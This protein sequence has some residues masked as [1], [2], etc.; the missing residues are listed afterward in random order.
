[1]DRRVLYVFILHLVY[2]HHDDSPTLKSRRFVQ[3]GDVTI[4]GLF[5]IHAGSCKQKDF[6][7]AYMAMSQ[8][9]VYAIDSINNDT[10]LLPNI[11]L[12]YEIYDSC[13]TDTLAMETAMEI[14]NRRKL[15]IMY[16]KYS[17]IQKCFSREQGLG[18]ILALIGTGSSDSSIL[19]ANLLQV[20]GI[21]LISYAA[22][23]DELSKRSYP[24]FLRTVPPDHF[25][26]QAMADIAHY[27]NWTYIAAIAAD[28][29]YG[30]SAIYYFKKA[31]NKKRTCL[32]MESY[33]SDKGP[34]FKDKISK[35]ITELKSLKN[36]QVVVVI[37]TSTQ[38]RLLLQEAHKQNVDKMTWIAS[39]GWGDSKMTQENDT[40]PVVKGLLGIIYRDV[41]V[42]DFVEYLMSLNSTYQPVHWWENFW[43]SQFKCVF[44]L[45]NPSGKLCTEDLRISKTMYHSH[46]H[47]SMSAYVI[48]AVYAI[49][50]ALDAMRKCK[51]P[52]GLLDGG[53]CPSFTTAIN[54]KD[55]LVYIKAV[56]FTSPVSRVSFDAHGDPSGT[57]NIVNL[58][59]RN[60]SWEFHRIGSWVSSS[61]PHLDIDDDMIMW[62]GDSKGEPPKSVCQEVCSPGHWQTAS[63][64]CCWQCIECPLDEISQMYGA[65]NCTKCPLG[66]I[67][68][69]NHTKCTKVPI[70]RISYSHPFGLC[71][72]VVSCLGLIATACITG[73]F[74][75]YNNSPIV[76]ASNRELC[77]MLLFCI[78]MCY[79]APFIYLAKP[80]Q[81]GCILVQVWFY[82]FYTT[83][84]AILG[85]K[86]NK[87][88]LLFEQRLPRSRY[89]SGFFKYR[90]VLIV[91][92]AML[93]ELVVIVI[94]VCVDPPHPY[95]NKD[96]R[97]EYFYTC[98]PSLNQAGQVCQ[99]LLMSILI[100]A[101]IICCYF[102]YKARRLPDNFNEGKFIAFSMYILSISWLTFYP[103]ILN[104]QDMYN[105]VVL[106]ITTFIAASG[107]LGCMFWP[108]IYIIIWCP[109]KN[110]KH[111]MQEQ[112]SQH[113]FRHNTI[114]TRRSSQRPSIGT[115]DRLRHFL[116]TLHSTA[117]NSTQGS[118]QST[119]PTTPRGS[120]GSLG[121]KRRLDRLGLDNMEW[122]RTSLNTQL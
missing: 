32:A 114:K 81:N 48:N 64:G 119:A 5:P 104:I 115:I 96:A 23:S 43:S 91:V 38:A 8:S 27:F 33:F 121:V 50:H 108:K 93:L 77:Y 74:I 65:A 67:S 46:L 98:K 112:I 101:S 34:E 69:L 31:I 26:S 6:R 89:A 12:G 106:S 63:V 84:I 17:N 2:C 105:V 49:A 25:Q 37:C 71:F 109:H 39:E 76:K 107:L 85:A 83:C 54:P 59:K 94:W 116:T 75:R 58:Q 111:Y 40:L 79:L 87:I 10:S 122:P 18:Q 35:I 15:S 20:E 30:R 103:V 51:E 62:N 99:Y 13:L 110:T 1:M 60:G 36:V 95:I 11:S 47:T 56:N 90:H 102:A 73:I 3:P 9:M 21:P 16:D 78:A 19:V 29:A 80:S 55:L 68:N 14:I 88:V 41:I 7:P 86:T 113:A 82:L 28:N 92:S 44:K 72:I 66:Y 117:D 52:H 61:S 42:E 45:S 120:T 118:P 70:V 57:Y 4:S 22:T 24:T 53:K 100:L 97:K